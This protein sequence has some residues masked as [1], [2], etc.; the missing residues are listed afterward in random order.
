MSAD[1]PHQAALR[2]HA[3]Q[4]WDNVYE[5][6]SADDAYLQAVLPLLTNS[7]TV[8]DLGCGTGH[9]L[10]KLLLQSARQPQRAIGVDPSPAML[11]IARQRVKTALRIEWLEGEAAHM[12][13][14][15]SSVDIV[16]SRL[17]EYLPEELARVLRPGGY[18]IE[19]GLGPLD[20]A[21]IAQ[22]FG[23]RYACEYV[24]VHPDRWLQQRTDALSTARMGTLSFHIIEGI[25]Y[26]TRT[27]L[28]E[29]IEMVPLVEPF[30]PATDAPLL[31]RM[32][33]VSRPLWPES[34]YVV[35]RQATIRVAQ[36]LS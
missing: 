26:L 16:L 32:A 11:A 25:D 21:E 27:Q 14:A 36:R 23:E 19:Y 35:H 10:E 2:D 9:V 12:P 34:R 33:K 8:V 7:S 30:S 6:R 4:T 31:D 29:S 22:A 18:F 1:S 24:P 20:S 17:S 28:V 13:F 3:I 5:G 15:P